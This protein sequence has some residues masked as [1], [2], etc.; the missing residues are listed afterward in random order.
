MGYYEIEYMKEITPY[1]ETYIKDEKLIE[2]LNSLKS[3]KLRR[4]LREYLEDKCYFKTYTYDNL[5]ADFKYHVENDK[6]NYFL[7]D[8]NDRLENILNM[9]LMK[10][11]EGDELW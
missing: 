4:I 2:F 8:F 10:R 6:G 7:P 9:L 5:K 1:T 11:E 3:T